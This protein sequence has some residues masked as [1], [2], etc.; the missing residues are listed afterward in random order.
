M[1]LE[2]LI[3]IILSGVVGAALGALYMKVSQSKQISE[4][5]AQYQLELEKYKLANQDLLKELE[6]AQKDHERLESSSMQSLQRIQEECQER[7]NDKIAALEEAKQRE[8]KLKE[9]HQIQIAQ[10]KQDLQEHYREALDKIEKQYNTA[11][12]EAKQKE[13]KLKEELKNAFKALSADILEQNTQSFNQT[14]IHSLKPLREDIERFSK[15]LKDNHQNALRDQTQLRTEIEN[16]NKLSIQLSTEAN[17]LANALKGSN[18]AQGDW[19]EQILQKVLENSGLSEGRDYELQKDLKDDDGKS[20]RPD[21]IIKLPKSNGEERCV[22]V[23]AKTS[24]ESYTKLCNAKDEKEREVAQK[25]LSMSIKAHFNNLSSKNYQYYLKGQKLD[26]VLMFIPIEGAFLE[27][28][29]QDMSLYDEAYKKGVVLVSPTTF[30]ALLKVIANLWQFEHRNKNIE[31]IFTEFQ[32]L[33]G[34]IARFE[35]EF[36]KIGNNIQTLQN[37]YK[38]MKTKYESNQGIKLKSEAINDLLK[39]GNIALDTPSLA[40]ES[41]PKEGEDEE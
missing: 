34:S 36:Q 9:E 40:I 28:M 23:D 7:V 20:L 31:K 37:T 17:N 5:K 15:E 14:Q 2:T 25:E 41:A 39:R 19:G 22:V 8:A 18:K 24:L 26:F 21:A 4:L 12:E 38:E 6:M 30:M 29:A 3:E 32:K 27:A 11:K 10:T 35:K 33:F 13:E 16:L 1:N